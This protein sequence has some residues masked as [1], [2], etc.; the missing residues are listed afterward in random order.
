MNRNGRHN[1]TFKKVVFYCWPVA[2]LLLSYF[3]LLNNHSLSDEEGRQLSKGFTF[4]STELDNDIEPKRTIRAVNQA[5]E[6]ISGWISSVG[7]ATALYDLNDDGLSNDLCLVDPRTDSIEIR[8]LHG[9]YDSFYLGYPQNSKNSI[10]PMGCL[11]GDFNEDGNGDVIVYFW[12]RSPLIF[13]QSPGASTIS[14]ADFFPVDLVSPTEA[15]YTNA[16]TQADF[17]GDGHI[18]L[19][20]GNYFPEDSAILDATSYVSEVMQHSM[21]RAGNAGM[22]RIFLYD[23][24][25][26]RAPFRDVSSLFPDQWRNG[27]TLAIGAADLDG[28]LLPEIYIA[29]DF[30]PDKLLHNISDGKRMAFR[31]VEAEYSVL[32]PRSHRL[33]HDSFKGMGVDFSDLNNDG[34]L[35]I[36]VSNI[37]QVYA[38]RE[39]H[40]AFVSTGDAS[41]FKRGIA[42][43][44]N[45]SEDMG[46]GLSAWSW[47][48]KFADF[49][50][51]GKVE[52]V[53]GTGF[54]KG[55]VDRWPQL[56]ELATGN[57]DLLRHA[58]V[59]PE[60]GKGD[61]LSGHVK[62]AFYALAGDGRYYDISTTMDMEVE[63]LVTRAISIAD[64]DGD[65]DLDFVA[66]NQWQPSVLYENQLVD[67]N[68][69]LQLSLKIPVASTPQMA[70]FLAKSTTSLPKSR[71]AIG[72]TAKLVNESRI[73][74][75]DGGNGHSGV[76]SPD[77]HFGLG[78]VAEFRRIPV[79]IRWIDL[80]GK[81]RRQTF[82]LLP[83]R[84]TIYLI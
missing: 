6:H 74:F 29:N 42:P 70:S 53:Q 81:K 64:I 83:G 51:D 76:N 43:Y 63:P 54:L 77:I 37:S 3:T 25:H 67:N 17:N 41:A 14:A 71:P 65:G 23:N 10:A 7:S 24:K 28:D 61:D 4:K 46:V 75:V 5:I 22:N 62:N 8:S 59:W 55:E 13:F 16:A 27:W 26:S 2:A 73:D 66:G 60:F 31:L 45:R 80:S 58:Q 36:Y 79:E 18:D 21:S 82:D 49:N 38:L 20:F 57:D 32:V 12:G 47:D 69:S 50:N 30:G 72:A 11:P 19:I 35:D 15:W 52:I 33:G 48:A 40:F 39:S 9:K 78:H 56:H 84:H 34:I 68:K 1:V 44:V